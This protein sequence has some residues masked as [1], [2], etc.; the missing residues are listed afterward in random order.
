MTPTSL[1]FPALRLSTLIM[2]C[3][4]LTPGTAP[5]DRSQPSPYPAVLLGAA[6]VAASR[7]SCMLVGSGALWMR[8]EA[9]AVHDAD[10]VIEPGEQN[11]GRLHAALASVATQPR[12]LPAAWRLPSL[13]IATVAPHTGELTV[14][15]SEGGSTGGACASPPPRFQWPES[16]CWSL[17]R[18]TR[19]TSGGASRGE[20]CGRAERA[21]RG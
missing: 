16:A 18:P 11:L 21:R 7:V 10:L 20:R 19:G 17:A 1:A 4:A 6:V 13:D 14:Y 15:L 12:L 2:I 3:E 9:I 5:A 8:G